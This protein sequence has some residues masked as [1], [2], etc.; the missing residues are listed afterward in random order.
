MAF[1]AGDP[2]P[3]GKNAKQWVTRQ[4]PGKVQLHRRKAAEQVAL[5]VGTDADEQT[6]QQRRECLDAALNENGL[7][8]QEARERIVLWIPKWHIETWILALLGQNVNEDDNYKHAAR[9]ADV[10]AAAKGF[11]DRFRTFKQDG[12][13]QLLPSLRTAFQETQ[14]LDV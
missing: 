12:T 1:S 10:P 13:I 8:P 9:D 7:P 14:R 4:Y 2:Y 6:V 11:A 5:L 3:V